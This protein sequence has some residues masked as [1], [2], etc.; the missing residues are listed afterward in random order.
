MGC[1]P[2]RHQALFQI[3]L[4]QV[5]IAAANFVLFLAI[6]WSSRS[7]PSRSPDDCRPD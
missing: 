6:I 2:E 1:P 3:N 5:I 7:I 4:F